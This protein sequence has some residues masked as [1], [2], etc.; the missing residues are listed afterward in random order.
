M[1]GGRLTIPVF[2][3]LGQYRSL[4]LELD[5][6]LLGAVAG[7][8]YILGDEVRALESEVA[9]FLGGGFGVGVASGTDALVLGLDAL[10]VGVG[11]EVIVPAFSFFASAEAVAR[12]GA[13]PVFADVSWESCCLDVADAARRVSERTR[14]VM[15]VHLYGHPADMG[16]VMEL[17]A[18][19][20][21][22][23]VEDNAQGFGS[24]VDGVMTGAIGD[25]GALSFFPTKT[26]GGF[27]DG[28]MVV[29]RDDEVAAR[30]RTLRAHG[31]ARKDHPVAIGYNS[32]LDEIQAAVLRV[33]LA[34]AQGWHERRREIA[35]RYSAGLAG[36]A[37]VETPGE[38]SGVELPGVE[39]PGE[40]DGVEHTY[41]L[42]VIKVRDRDAVR[43]RLAAAGVASGVYYAVPLPAT[44]VFSDGYRAGDY[45]VAERLAAEVLALPMFPHMSDEQVDEVVSAVRS[46][47]GLDAQSP[48]RE[49]IGKV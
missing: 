20:D 33:K 17:A 5:D 14:A 35:A 48:G 44:D 16:A 36:V 8:A 41:G 45:P 26:L 13:K 9:D 29:A 19:H 43:E 31:F 11:D 4:R 37:G 46:A 23:V 38:A 39:S 28:G 34:H 2:D 18:A 27:G 22:A 3:P 42:Y 47:V 7:G 21:L 25:V 12:V 15:P 1:G 32:R 24:S 40:A 49:T 10:G 6:A 30:V